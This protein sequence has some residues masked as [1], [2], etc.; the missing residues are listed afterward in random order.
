M[1]MLVANMFIKIHS[2]SDYEY[3]VPRTVTNKV[4]NSPVIILG[5]LSGEFGLVFKWSY[6]YKLRSLCTLPIDWKNIYYYSHK[7]YKALIS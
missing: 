5:G 7:E 3:H 2:Y 1:G 4:S 6:P